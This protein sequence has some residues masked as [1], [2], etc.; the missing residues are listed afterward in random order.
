MFAQYIP[1][2]ISFET[3]YLAGENFGDFDADWGA[4]LWLGVYL[5]TGNWGLIYI[6]TPEQWTPALADVTYTDVPTTVPGLVRGAAGS[7]L[8]ATN[9]GLLVSEGEDFA[10]F[11]D[12]ITVVTDTADEG[13]PLQNIVTAVVQDEPDWVAE[14]IGMPPLNCAS[15]RRV[16]E[17]NTVY[18]LSEQSFVFRVLEPFY[19]E[20]YWEQWW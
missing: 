18:G 4:C 9:N 2:F 3:G 13:G 20:E 12:E 6:L 15:E 17:Y 10:L 14:L 5:N 1:Q 7:R 16:R 19:G 8:L 11:V